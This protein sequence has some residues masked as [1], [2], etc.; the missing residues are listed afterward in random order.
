M[1][2][3]ADERAFGPGFA[4]PGSWS[5]TTGD[6]ERRRFTGHSLC[7]A[8]AVGRTR[9]RAA[10]PRVCGGS[11]RSRPTP[12]A[13]RSLSPFMPAGSLASRTLVPAATRPAPPLLGLFALLQPSACGSSSASAAAGRRGSCRRRERRLSPPGPY[14]WLRHP[15]YLVAT[16]EIA[17]LPLALPPMLSPCG[18]FS[19]LN[20]ALVVRRIAIEERVL[21]P[22]RGQDDRR[23]SG[24]GRPGSALPRCASACSWR[25]SI[26]R[27]SPARCPRC[28][29]GLGILEF[30]RLSW[31][32][33]A[34][35]TAE[36]VAIPLTGWLT[37]M[38]STR[39]AFVACVGGFTAAS[40]ACA[41]STGFWIPDPGAGGSG[42]L[43]R[44]FDPAGLSR[45]SS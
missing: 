44:R 37:L 3:G 8:A 7:R 41:V 30:D 45:R 32:Q 29:A 9:R 20:L 35:L 1:E 38:L 26:S 22:R 23:H 40:L 34:Y 14:R 43:R 36:I 39:G 2:L 33:T 10:T 21:A 18:A 6:A 13:T 42:L 16:A 31:V 27:S 15:N 19:A 17:L 5:S 11:A 4:R 24:A 12:P 28:E 25:S